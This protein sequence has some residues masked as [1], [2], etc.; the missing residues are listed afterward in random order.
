MDGHGITPK[1]FDVLRTLEFVQSYLHLVEAIAEKDGL[2]LEMTGLEVRPGS[3]AFACM[4][5][6][7]EEVRG[8][9]TRANA[10]IAGDE[11]SGRGLKVRVTNVRSAIRRLPVAYVPYVKAPTRLALPTTF[12]EKDVHME[13]TSLRGTVLITGGVEP[14]VKLRTDIGTIPL[15][16]SQEDVETV[17]RHL[18][19]EIDASVEIT[20]DSNGNVSGKLLNFRPVCKLSSDEEFD[21]WREWFN[22]VGSDWNS[23]DDI[24]RELD[25][26]D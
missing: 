1:S 20:R 22:H 7:V 14:K 13:M 15:R 17:A 2:S 12:E 25:R 9:A 23:V 18:Y 19:G 8:I 5:A 4:S 26:V 16:A 6:H 3:V 10:L 21:R 11:P 24:E